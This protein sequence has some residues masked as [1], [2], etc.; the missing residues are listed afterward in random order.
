MRKFSTNTPRSN[1][2]HIVEQLFVS[3]NASVFLP[4][5]PKQTSY[6]TTSSSVFS[7]VAC[8]P[9]EWSKNR[10]H[11]ESHHFSRLNWQETCLEKAVVRIFLELSHWHQLR[12]NF[13]PFFRSQVTGRDR[14]LL[15]DL[16]FCR[17][18]FRANDFFNRSLRSPSLP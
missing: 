4:Y 6:N 18:C 3:Q 14:E 2:L 13:G 17:G 10:F 12:V 16:F 9:W 15:S 1:L 7:R 8:G 5:I 11:T